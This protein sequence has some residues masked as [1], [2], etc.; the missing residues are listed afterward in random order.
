M[1]RESF[2]QYILGIASRKP[3]IFCK[4]SERSPP[5]ESIWRHQNAYENVPGFPDS[6]IIHG[7]CARLV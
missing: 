5:D 4:R 6:A 2:N 1:L 7:M 3:G